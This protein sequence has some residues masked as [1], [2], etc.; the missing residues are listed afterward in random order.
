MVRRRAVA[1]AGPSRFPTGLIVR[2]L[3]IIV[4]LA[5]V[6]G[7]VL[8]AAGG[9]F[10]YRIVSDFNDTENVNP[11]SFLLSNYENLNFTDPTGEEH[12]GWLL[13]GLK[14]APVIVLCHGYDSNRSE[15]LSLGTVLQENHFNVYIFNFRGVKPRTLSSDFGARQVAIVQAAIDK[16]T[17]Q[18]GINRSRLGLFGKTTGGYAALVVAEQ[19]PIVKAIVVDNAY[20][21]PMQ[22]FNAQV[23]EL[24][25]S[26]TVF[27][28]IMDTEFRLLNLGSKTPLLDENFSK[29]DPIPKFFISGRDIPS[30]AAVTESFYDRAPQPKRLIVMDRSQTG[31]MNDTEKKEYE[32]QILAFY[33]QNLSLRAD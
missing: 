4:I 19:N 26:T 23:D 6:A 30:L 12:A 21:K 13:R 15:L 28:G 2:L 27:R 3:S 29:L 31:S 24:L 8:S 1:R 14:G 18:A 7:V 32:N 22:M 10:A 9:F 20:E 17:K 11:E 16:V 33:Q 25:G 5:A